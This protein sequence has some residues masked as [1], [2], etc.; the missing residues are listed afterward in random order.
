MACF[1]GERHKHLLTTPLLLSDIIF[2]D[3]IAAFEP[4]LIAQA[5]K[6]T[7][8]GMTLLTMTALIL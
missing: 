6:H 3:C 7:L 1:V 5:V 4:A 8:G 2:D